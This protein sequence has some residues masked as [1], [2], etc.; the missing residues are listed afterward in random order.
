MITRRI[1]AEGMRNSEVLQLD[2]KFQEAQG[3]DCSA[4]LQ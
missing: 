3:K 4:K 2:V 1:E